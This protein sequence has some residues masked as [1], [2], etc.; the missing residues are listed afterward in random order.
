MRPK[1]SR[2]P[3]RKMSD[4]MEQK[5]HPSNFRT[6]L[7]NPYSTIFTMMLHKVLLLSRHFFGHSSAFDLAGRD[8][9]PCDGITKKRWIENP[10]KLFL[11]R[12]RQPLVIRSFEQASKQSKAK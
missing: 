6:Y 8:S 3:R 11:F 4:G 5:P 12:S 1:S 9:I 2:R 7:L 10:L